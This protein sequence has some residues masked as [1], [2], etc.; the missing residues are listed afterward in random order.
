Q[1]APG[2]AHVAPHRAARAGAVR[3]VR[4]GGRRRVR[5]PRESAAPDRRLR[6]ARPRPRP[7][8]RGGAAAVPPERG[9]RLGLRAERRRGPRADRRPG[10]RQRPLPEAVARVRR[11]RGRGVRDGAALPAG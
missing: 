6:W 2:P 10:R 3:L 11:G 4:G 5:R 9:R 1:V 8:R 7:R